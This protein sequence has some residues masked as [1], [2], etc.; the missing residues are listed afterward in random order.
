MIVIVDGAGNG[1]GNGAKIFV[2]VLFM[3]TGSCLQPLW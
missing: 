2:M 1:R 3:V